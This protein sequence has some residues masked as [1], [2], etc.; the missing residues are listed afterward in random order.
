M[1]DDDGSI[2]NWVQSTYT[3]CYSITKV[4]SLVG[5]MVLRF[6]EYN[7]ERVDYDWRHLLHLKKRFEVSDKDYVMAYRSDRNFA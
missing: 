1:R 2:W 3:L 7:D 5:R 4:I 6:I